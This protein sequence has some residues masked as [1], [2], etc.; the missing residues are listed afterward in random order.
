MRILSHT[1]LGRGLA[2]RTIKRATRKT[3]R[4]EKYGA[5]MVNQVVGPCHSA[6]PKWTGWKVGQNTNFVIL[7]PSAIAA[8]AWL[9]SCT[10]IAIIA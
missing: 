10:I 1:H 2:S 9:P 6:Y 5:A 7:A 4:P 3:I 8:R